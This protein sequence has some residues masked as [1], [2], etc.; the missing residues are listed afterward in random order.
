MTAQGRA[1]VTIRPLRN[2]GRSANITFYAEDGKPPGYVYAEVL[3]NDMT[4]QGGRM[5]RRR[6]PTFWVTVRQP[7]RGEIASFRYEPATR[8]APG[9]LSERT[10]TRLVRRKLDEEAPR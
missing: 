8:P 2:A 4:R 1:A 7:G 5:V 3:R 9:P 6:V 10:V